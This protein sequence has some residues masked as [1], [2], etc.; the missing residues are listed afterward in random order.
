MLKDRDL[1]RSSITSGEWLETRR[2]ESVQPDR[3]RFLISMIICDSR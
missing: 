2:L 1:A 3:D